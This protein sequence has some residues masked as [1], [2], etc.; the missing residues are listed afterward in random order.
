MENEGHTEEIRKVFIVYLASHD[1]PINELLDPARKDVRQTYE[2]EFAGLTVDDARYEDLVAAREALI[3]TLRKDVTD[4]EKDFLVSLKE[5]QPKWDLL[6]LEGIEKL[7]AIQWK[8]MNIRQMKKEKHAA[9]LA[10]LKSTL[11]V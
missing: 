11:G 5:G 8:L 7:P 6:G 10:K 1:R 2:R 4:A 9:E 3:E